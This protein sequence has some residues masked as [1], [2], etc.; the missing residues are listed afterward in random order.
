MRRIALIALGLTGLA[1]TACQAVSAQER[2][3]SL[4]DGIVSYDDLRRE[5]DK[6][7]SSG[8][9]IRAKQDGGD[10]AQLSNYTCV[11]PPSGK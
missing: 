8:G 6:C 5:G 7:K 10:P 1:L 9:T 11:I 2:S 4:G 3:Y